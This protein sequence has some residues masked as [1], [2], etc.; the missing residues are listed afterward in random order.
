MYP[1]IF[2]NKVNSILQGKYLK[3]ENYMVIVARGNSGVTKWILH[4][5]LTNEE[6]HNLASKMIYTK[7]SLYKLISDFL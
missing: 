4:T 2:V 5:S 7:H 6:R 3:Y 1:E